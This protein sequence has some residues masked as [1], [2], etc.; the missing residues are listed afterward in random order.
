MTEGAG[1][2]GTAVGI[3]GNGVAEGVGDVGGAI[4]GAGVGGGAVAG[5]ALAQPPINSINPST[6]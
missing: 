6:Y 5:G 4:E 2:V 1:T 3:G